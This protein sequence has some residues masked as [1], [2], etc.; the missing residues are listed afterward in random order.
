M[1]KIYVKLFRPGQEVTY[2]GWTYKVSYVRV[3]RGELFVHLEGLDQAVRE[4]LLEVAP[5]LIDFERPKYAP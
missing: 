4:D 1:P 5:T 2:M 3:S